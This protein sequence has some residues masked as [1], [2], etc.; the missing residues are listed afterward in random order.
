MVCDKCQKKLTKVACPDKWVEGSN[1]SLRTG[2]VKVN[3]NKL[4]SK[5]K[6]WAPYAASCKTCKQKM[7]QEGMYCQ[8][9]AYSKGMCAMCGKQIM[10]TAGYKQSAK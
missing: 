7:H 1:N 6:R 2:G 5:K 4:L 8:G 3:E 9:C 10:D